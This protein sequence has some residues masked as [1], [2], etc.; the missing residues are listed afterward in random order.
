MPN[1]NLTHITLLLDRSG[2]MNNIQTDII[3]GVNAFFDAQRKS[4]TPITTT[5]VQFDSKDP[6][7]II[8]ENVS[9]DHVPKLSQD[10]YRPRGQTPLFDAIGQGITSLDSYLCELKA[11]EAPGDVV[12][13]IV[14]DGKENASRHFTR[15]HI[16]DLI[17]N[18]ELSGWKFIFLSSDLSAVNEARSFLIRESRSVHFDKENTADSFSLMSRKI[19]NYLSINNSESLDFDDNERKSLLKKK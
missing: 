14:T 4:A 12:F 11:D 1:Q 19:A 7:E 3:G 10:I 17:K 15:L 8:A 9:L 16:M 13:V 18:K 5:L 6:F 2:S